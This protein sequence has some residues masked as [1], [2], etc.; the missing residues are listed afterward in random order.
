MEIIIHW[1][2]QNIASIIAIFISVVSL[3]VTIVL[4]RREK[5]N[6]MPAGETVTNPNHL[7]LYFLNTSQFNIHNLTILVNVFDNGLNEVNKVPISDKYLFS[8]GEKTERSTPFGSTKK[9]L[10]DIPNVS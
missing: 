10:P 3:L 1:I 4:D 7:S 8:I 6:L 5:P 2:G 9:R